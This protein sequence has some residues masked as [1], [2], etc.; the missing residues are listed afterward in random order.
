[1]IGILAL[2][3]LLMTGLIADIMLTSDSDEDEGEVPQA[4]ETEQGDDWPDLLDDDDLSTTPLSAANVPDQADLDA[5]DSGADAETSDASAATN[6]IDGTSDNEWMVGDSGHDTLHGDFGDDTIEGDDGDD[7][8]SGGMGDD[9]LFGQAGD[10]TLMG[11]SGDDTLF[12]GAGNDWL[13]GGHGND[14][15]HVGE[16]SDTLD[17]GEGDDTLFGAI[18][19][20]AGAGGNYLNGGMGNDMLLVG[21]GDIASGEAGSDSFVLGDWMDGA[22]AQILDFDPAEDE[23][24]VVFDPSMTSDPVLTLQTGDSPEH[25]TIL[26]D[27]VPLAQVANAGGLDVS[28]IRL[29][30]EIPT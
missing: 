29:V 7:W 12:A 27:G 19:G 22:I 6:W 2:M 15:L 18:N 1:M 5:P 20:V 25:L 30:A 23:I 26:L 10:D 17:G 3:G 21:S 8:I 24:V 16:G 14:V 28:S 11:G 9:V 4:P 13:S